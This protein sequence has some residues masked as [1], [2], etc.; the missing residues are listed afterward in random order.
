MGR[1]PKDRAEVTSTSQPVRIP[2]ALLF[3][4]DDFIRSPENRLAYR[5]RPE[6]VVAAIREFL[7]RNGGEKEASVPPRAEK[8]VRAAVEQILADMIRRDR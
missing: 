8:E 5:D 6:V 7:Q 2:T 1:R 3:E 4:I